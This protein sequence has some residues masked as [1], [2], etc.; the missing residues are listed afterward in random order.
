MASPRTAPSAPA[1]TATTSSP[2][3]S[4]PCRTADS[5]QTEPNA[6]GKDILIHNNQGGQ[7]VTAAF[8]HDFNP[9]IRAVGDG[10]YLSSYVYREAFTENFNQAVSSDIDSVVYI[11]QQK[12][13]YSIDARFDRY[14]GLKV[15]PVLT[16]AGE[17]VKIFHAPS[18]DFTGVDR[19]IPGT[20]LLWSFTASAAGLKRV[21]PNFVSSGI[22]ERMDLRP[23]LAL[24]LAFAGWHTFSF[25]AMETPST[26][27]RA[28]RPTAPTL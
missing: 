25:I 28:K 10:E 3:T 4:P 6:R 13:G 21:Q 27:A 2:P 24:P 5:I 16:K 7:D 8:R 23:E 11:T 17:E 26:P 9:Y 12:N 15:V 1:D 22:I 19:A 20:P 14:Q 18:F